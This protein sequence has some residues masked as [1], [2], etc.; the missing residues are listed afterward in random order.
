MGY[1]LGSWHDVKLYELKIQEHGK[2]PAEPKSISEISNTDEFRDIINKAE[3]MIK[4]ST[5]NEA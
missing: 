5:F 3:Q 4:R 2:S 1:K